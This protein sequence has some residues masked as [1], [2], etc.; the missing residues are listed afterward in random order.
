MERMWLGDA[1]KK[2][3]N[4]WIVAVNIMYGEKNKAFGDIFL[5]TSSKGEAYSKA[6][7]LKKSGAVGKVSVTE[8]QSDAPQIGGL[9]A[10]SR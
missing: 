3:P 8:G 6:S 5:V 1:R 4:M 7:E 10:W 2:Y 9:V